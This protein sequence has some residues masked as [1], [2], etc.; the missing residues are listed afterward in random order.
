[1]DFARPDDS[2]SLPFLLAVA[3][4]DQVLSELIAQGE[5][6]CKSW[7]LGPKM[8]ASCASLPWQDYAIID[9]AKDERNRLAHEGILL[10]KADCLRYIKAIEYELKSLSII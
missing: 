3:T 9:Q 10:G 1:M 6:S 2:Y 5:F 4:L 7:M 8:E